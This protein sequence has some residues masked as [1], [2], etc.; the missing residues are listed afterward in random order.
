MQ[1]SR[2]TTCKLWLV[3]W[4]IRIQNVIT[5]LAAFQVSKD[6]SLYAGVVGPL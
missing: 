5:Q 2:A 4:R 1:Q 6:F 3:Y